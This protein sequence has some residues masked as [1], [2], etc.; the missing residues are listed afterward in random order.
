M[1]PNEWD[2]ATVA[3]T[4]GRGAGAPGEPINVPITLSS[5]FHSLDGDV[6]YAREHNPTSQA[7]ED[8]VGALEGGRACTFA[9]GIAAIAAVLETVPVGGS[10][11]AP[12]DAYTGFRRLLGDLDGKGRLEARLVDITDTDGVLAAC[13]GA[14]LLWIESPTNPMMAVAD[15]P[16]L[17]TGAH[18]GGV[19]VAVDN[20]FA[21]PL[22]QRPLNL[23]ADVVVHSA[24]KFLGGHSDVLVGA[25]VTRD[26]ALA[27]RI[28]SWRTLGGAVPGPVEAWLVLRGIRTLP[29][30]MERAQ[31]NAGELARRL[32]EHP[33]V[34]RV[35]YPGLPSDPGHELAS[36]QM[37]GFGAMLSLEVHGGAVAAD[38][39]CDRIRLIT[40]ATSLGGVETTME[41]RSKQEGEEKVP[42][43]LVRVSVG[44]EHI[45]DLWADVSQALEGPPA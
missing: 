19:A 21:T 5:V 32:S 30:R 4:A 35:R 39:L 6:A 25:T 10:V 16:A 43:S 24:T 42:A 23:G 9:S 45:E 28:V 40:H 2:A 11:V 14:N 13:D 1:T 44:C 34:E 41:R 20:T 3:V 33:A 15:L 17:V 38:A 26:D 29:V 36:R 31:V 18:A 7:L 12:V 8:A 27:E 22:L 37:R